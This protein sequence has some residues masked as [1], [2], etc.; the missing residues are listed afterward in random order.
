MGMQVDIFKEFQL[1]FRPGAVF[2]QTTPFLSRNGAM[3]QEAAESAEKELRDLRLLLF[4]AMVAPTS[5]LVVPWINAD[6]I[7][8]KPCLTPLIDPKHG[9][10]DAMTRALLQ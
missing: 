10:A 1:I 3:Q 6:E 7:Q 5:R 4:H 8:N 9:V 2:R